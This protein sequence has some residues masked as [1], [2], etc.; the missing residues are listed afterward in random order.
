MSGAGSSA[1]RVPVHPEPVAGSASELRWT[2]PAGILPVGAVRSAPGRLGEMLA[3]GLLADPL[4]E[5]AALWLRLVSGTWREHGTAVR[6]A[7]QDALL[8]PGGWVVD[9]PDDAGL[10]RVTAE[11][12][13]GT[14]GDYVRSHGG[15]ITV[16]TVHD[17]T[18]D[19]DLDGTCEHCPAAGLTL[20]AR[21]ESAVRDRWPALVAVRDVHGRAEGH[22]PQDARAALA[23]WLG[24]GRA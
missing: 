14:V 19:L 9:D 7:L 4:A 21:V 23:R 24:L 20:H 22:D 8:D 3:D 13:A 6:E 11:V 5:R 18:V 17:A 15:R 10:E 16:A 1:R 2:V 12:L